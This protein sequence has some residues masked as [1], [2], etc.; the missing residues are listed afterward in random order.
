M[1]RNLVIAT[2]VWDSEYFIYS[3]LLY[4]M[5]SKIS[6]LEFFLNHQTQL[7]QREDINS[8]HA[9]AISLWDVKLKYW[10]GSKVY[11]VAHYIAYNKALTPAVTYY[12]PTIKQPR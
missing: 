4:V 12:S 1:P 2:F 11:F 8:K 3:Q 9:R 5:D 6:L 7:H 10:Q